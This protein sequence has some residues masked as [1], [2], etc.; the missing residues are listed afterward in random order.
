MTCQ[1]IYEILSLTVVLPT[2]FPTNMQ[3]LLDNPGAAFHVI[4]PSF[5]GNQGNFFL[6][7]SQCPNGF[8]DE[9]ICEKLRYLR[10]QAN[11]HVIITGIES[12]QHKK[13]SNRTHGIS[14][15][16][17]G[18]FNVKTL[19]YSAQDNRKCDSVL[20]DF[21]KVETLTGLE[22]DHDNLIESWDKN[23]YIMKQQKS[24][25]SF[26]SFYHYKKKDL[27]SET[28]MDCDRNALQANCL[29]GVNLTTYGYMM[30][31]G[32]LPFTMEHTG[33]D[34]AYY[35]AEGGRKNILFNNFFVTL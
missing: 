27:F 31:P 33:M 2:A 17:G 16:R 30:G 5:F 25:S 21:Q 9:N 11:Q 13:T 1:K 29:P 6:S 19:Y 3:R 26:R 34:C 18:F 35:I 15:V 4:V 20:K 23:L 10:R 32:I 7:S 8:P 12:V 22:I 28:I 24:W 14:C